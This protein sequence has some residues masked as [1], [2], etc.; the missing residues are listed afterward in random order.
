[1]LFSRAVSIH[2]RSRAGDPI[3]YREQC[4]RLSFNPRPLTSGRRTQATPVV[5]LPIVSI[6]ARSRA[7]DSGA[8]TKD[9]RPVRFNPRPLT[10]G[11]RNTR[12]RVRSPP[13]FNPR[14]LTSGRQNQSNRARA[15]VRFNPRPLTSGRQ[16]T[17][18]NKSAFQDVSI[19]ARSR[20]GDV[21]WHE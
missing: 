12:W 18:I 14:P 19:H 9:G 7:G 10:S 5:P 2:A 16:S 11:R 17:H 13:C 3:N 21:T 1:M 4:R 8:K 15:K 20:A 6:H